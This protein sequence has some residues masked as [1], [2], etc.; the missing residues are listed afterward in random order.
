MLVV[1]QR[2][3][4]AVNIDWGPRIRPSC[5]RRDQPDAGV[6]KHGIAVTNV[7]FVLLW[8]LSL[9]LSNETST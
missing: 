2:N 7:A 8:L 3:A 6:C 1:K 4:H 5:V 9:F